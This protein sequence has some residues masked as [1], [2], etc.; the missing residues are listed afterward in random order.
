MGAGLCDL[1][2]CGRMSLFACIIVVGRVC[3]SVQSAH[4]TD[5]QK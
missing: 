4:H 2:D 5:A 3:E 1:H